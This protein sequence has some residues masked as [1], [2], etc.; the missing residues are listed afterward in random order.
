MARRSATS[1]SAVRRADEFVQRSWGLMMEAKRELV[2]GELRE[3]WKDSQEN[4][5]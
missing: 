1:E 3:A 5:G 4:N 2:L